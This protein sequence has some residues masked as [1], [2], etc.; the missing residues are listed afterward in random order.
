MESGC[1]G[2][3]VG[4]NTILG[5]A[6]G[7]GDDGLLLRGPGDEVGVQEHG[8]AGGG[9]VRVGAA[10]PIN[11]DVDHQL[12]SWRGSK[13]EVVVEG[14]A[15]VVK[16]LLD[17]DEV[18]LPHVM[19]HLLDHVGDVDPGEGEVLESLG[20]TSVGRHVVD[21]G[22]TVVGDLRLSVNRREHD[23]VDVEKEVDGIVAAP[24]D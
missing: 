8:V 3:A 16:N 11:V 20:E 15:K 18:G 24:K 5:L 12:R 4:H 10:S 6:A 23:V 19:A 13:E 17:N 9:P 7:A 22:A 1:L 2:D 14:A 21:L